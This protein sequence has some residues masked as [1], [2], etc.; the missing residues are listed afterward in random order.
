MSISRTAALLAVALVL[1]GTAY[2]AAWQHGGGHA[3]AWTDV[4]PALGGVELR[5]PGATSFGRRADLERYLA[6]SVPGHLD[7]RGRAAVLIAAG[8]RSSDGFSIDVL[9]VREERSRVVVS[10]RE[11]TPALSRPTPATLSFPYRL[12]AIAA[13]GKHVDVEWRGRP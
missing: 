12:I 9:G 11:R 13:T 2:R 3:I 7:L 10:V 4:S 6:P 5:R 8:A 1:A